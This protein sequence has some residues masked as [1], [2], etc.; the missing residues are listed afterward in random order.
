MPCVLVGRRPIAEAISA[1]S[2]A[3]WL[4]LETILVD[5]ERLNLRV[6]RGPRD[7]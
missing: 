3:P 6:E 2:S 7:P 1:G 5:V 4:R